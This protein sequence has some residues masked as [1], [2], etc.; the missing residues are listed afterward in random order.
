[1]A[2]SPEHKFISLSL[3]KSL[4]DFSDTRLLGIREAQRRTFDYGCVVL[5]DFSRPLVSQVLWNHQEGI[6]KDIRTLLFDA[7]SSLKLY[8]IRD[9]VKNRAKLDELLKAYREQL[10]TAPLLRGLRIIPVPDA[11]DA[12]SESHQ[13]WMEGFIRNC[14]SRDLLFAVVF[15]KLSASDL[16]TFSDHGGPF[17]LKFA[18]LQEI[19]TSGLDHGPSFERA[20]GSKGPPLREAL[21]MLSGTGLA[22][23][24]RNSNYE[25]AHL[26]RPFLPGFVPQ[27]IVRAPSL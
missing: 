6:E 16:A 26:E 25:S 11:F 20:V 19:T 4:S 21:T 10:S 8:F 27:D 5:R 7:G 9:N 18:A 24:V 1:M 15:G 2:D 12:D 14:I 23:A 22:G 13:N 3:D 17:G